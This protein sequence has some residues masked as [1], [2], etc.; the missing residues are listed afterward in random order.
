MPGEQLLLINPRRRRRRRVRARARVRRRHVARSHRRSR[1]RHRNPF[2]A[3]HA[4]PRRRR[5]RIH[6]RHH[7]RRRR[8]P[9]LGGG[10]GGVVKD[11]TAAATGAAGAV[12]MNIVWGY[13]SPM[14]PASLAS[15]PYINAAAKSAGAF[16]L[17]MVAG[18]VVGRERGKIV[19]I[20]ALT[21][22]L[23]QFIQ[24][25]VQQAAPTLPFAGMGAYMVPPY[26][27]G[28]PG[29]LGAYL[30]GSGTAS[31]LPAPIGPNQ[32]FSLSGLGMNPSPYL[33]GYMDSGPGASDSM[34]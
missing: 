16:G 9:F 14:L 24:N 21:V 17:G 31:L 5:R 26:G 13:L 4:Q 2:Y 20:G 3:A 6:R 10:R 11:L 32:H 7:A 28:V 1:R 12:A 22:I 34:F 29:P 30:P 33:T 8:N 27:S 15:N 19:T 23:A 25:L 18:K